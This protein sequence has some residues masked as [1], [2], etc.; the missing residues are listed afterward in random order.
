MRAAPVRPVVLL[1]RTIARLPLFCNPSRPSAPALP[2]L[3][4][5]LSLRV[6]SYV[7]SRCLCRATHALPPHLTLVENPRQPP[8][9]CPLTAVFPLHRQQPYPG[10]HS[11]V[12]VDP[13]SV[14]SLVRFLRVC[15]ARLHPLCPTPAVLFSWLLFSVPR[16]GSV[17]CVHPWRLLSGPVSCQTLVRPP[18]VSDHCFVVNKFPPLVCL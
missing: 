17:A 15:P 14:V 18:V 10:L 9:P 1:W 8:A 4:R 3:R 7:M 5:K 6:C 13:G 2:L 16:A 11:N 12:G